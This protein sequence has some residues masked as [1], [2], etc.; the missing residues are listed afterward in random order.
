MPPQLT[1]ARLRMQ[2][3]YGKDGKVTNHLTGTTPE[4]WRGN[5][6]QLEV[7]VF[8]A[9]PNNAPPEVVDVTNITSL[10]IE[11]KA[12]QTSGAAPVISKTI[13][14]FAA[15]TS[16][17]WEA[18]TGQHAVVPLTAAETNLSLGGQASAELWM[19]FSV[20]TSEGYAITLGV[21]TLSVKEDNAGVAGTPPTNDPTYLTAAETTALVADKVSTAQLL[22]ALGGA[23]TESYEYGETAIANG[24]ESVAVEFAVPKISAAW[25]LLSWY[26]RNASDPD[27]LRL[28][29][30]TLGAQTDE[31]FTAL[32][33]GPTDSANYMLVWHVVVNP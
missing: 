13:D 8:L 32:L 33:N 2:V 31:G 16:E 18:G 15:L 21:S 14:S 10:T 27:P 9:R 25:H 6:V 17:A 23:A 1:R 30:V 26:V 3:I 4:I 12:S 19:T 28:W 7:G 20:V 24:A 11:A 22:A 29:P 5:D